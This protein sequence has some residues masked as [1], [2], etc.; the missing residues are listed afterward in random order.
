MNELR[1]YFEQNEERLINKFDHYFD[2]YERYFS[3]FR[4]KKITI[5]EIGVYQGGSLQM[6]RKYFGKEATIW[7]ID[8]DPR[9]KTLE[10]E[11]TPILIGSQEDPQ[12]LRSIIDKIGMIDILI[13]DG[14]HTQDQQIISFEELYKYVNPDGGIYLCED[15][16]T[17]Y[18]NVYGGG[19]QRNNTFIEY[20]KLLVDQLNAHYSE[21]SSFQ[22]NDITRTTNSIHFYDSIVVFEKKTMIPPSSKMMGKWSFEYDIKKKTFLEKIKFHA[23]VRMN[24]TLQSLKLKGIS[25]NEMLRLSS[26][27]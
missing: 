17:S 7:G 23:L 9:C 18:M 13:D 21:Q 1:E 3:K 26:K 27:K 15:V 16:H 24:K 5:V 22:I 4:N 2:V 12:F 25:V 8:I 11:N 14:G 20:S 6:W 19:H 10:D